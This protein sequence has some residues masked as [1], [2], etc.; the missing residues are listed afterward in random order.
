M[1][2]QAGIER[3]GA[4]LRKIVAGLVAM[5]GAGTDPAADVAALAEDRPT[6]ARFRHRA[7]LRIRSRVSSVLIRSNACGMVCLETL[8][9][10][11]KSGM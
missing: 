2:W 4:A 3:Q 1:D 11:P 6:L 8:D 5:V 7:L 10:D 9:H